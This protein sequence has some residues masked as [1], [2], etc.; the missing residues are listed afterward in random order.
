MCKY[1]EGSSDSSIQYLRVY[2][3]PSMGFGQI[4]H[5]SHRFPPIKQASKP[6]IEQLFIGITAVPLLFKWRTSYLA[7]GFIVCRIHIQIRPLMSFLLH[8]PLGT[9]KVVE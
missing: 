1:I 8:I 7:S 6:M 3:L 9:M 5:T 4:Y 2:N